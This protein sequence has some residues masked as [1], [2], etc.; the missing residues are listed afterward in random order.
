MIQKGSRLNVIDNS[1]AK[2]IECIQVLAGYRA[3]YGIRGSLIIASI[4]KMRKKRKSVLKVKKG[5][6]VK[7]L[8][9]RTKSLKK[10]FASVSNFFLENSV[11]LLTRQNK[12]IGT[13]VFGAIPRKFRYTRYAKLISISSGLLA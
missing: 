1:G 2:E 8:I 3:R 12:F 10:S 6:V 11:V 13:R 9:V 4:K 5:D 7:A